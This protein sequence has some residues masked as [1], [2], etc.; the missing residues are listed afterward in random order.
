MVYI[1]SQII[2]RRERAASFENLFA[3]ELFFRASVTSD[4]LIVRGGKIS[5]LV[6]ARS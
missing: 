6:F 3:K 2:V 1:S 4:L 5:S